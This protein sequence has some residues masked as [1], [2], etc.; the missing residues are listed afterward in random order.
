MDRLA[1]KVRGA[2]AELNFVLPDAERARLDGLTLEQLLEWFRAQ[3]AMFSR[4]VSVF[5]GV[6]WDKGTQK[7]RARISNPATGKQENLGL[8]A[9]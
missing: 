1:Y 7:W 3:A 8:F 4:G 9:F 5:R 2:D 6:C